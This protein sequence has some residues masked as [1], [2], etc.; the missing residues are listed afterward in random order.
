MSLRALIHLI[1]RRP[2]DKCEVQ[3]ITLDQGQSGEGH[4]VK[5]TSSLARSEAV[6]GTCKFGGMA[7]I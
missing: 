2:P 6:T 1:L 4:L 7:S 5:F 3:L